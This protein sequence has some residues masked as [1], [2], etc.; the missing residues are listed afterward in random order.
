MGYMDKDG[1]L[2]VLGRFKSLLISSDGEKYSP[3]GIEET[4]VEYSK[5]IDQVI[6]YNNQNAYTVALIVPSKEALK[7]AVKQKHSNITS[8]EAYIDAIN[9]IQKDIAMFKVG[10]EHDTMFPDRWL[11]ATFAI[12]NEPFSEQNGMVNSTLKVVRTKVEKHYQ[13]R[14]EHLYTPEGKVIHNQKNL[15]TIKSLFEN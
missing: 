9:Q 10:G 11:P 15:D 1:F 6:L 13:D 12:L 14:I 2:Y 5:H 4:L 7:K 3:E 8:Q